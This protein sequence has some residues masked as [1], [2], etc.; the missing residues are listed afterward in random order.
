M[1]N[2]SD[3]VIQIIRLATNFLF[4]WSALYDFDV[5]SEKPGGPPAEVCTGFTRPGYSCQKCL[6]DC[7]H[8]DKSETYCVYGF[9][10]NRHQVEQLLHT[11]FQ[12]EDAITVIRPM[13]EQAVSVSVGIK[14]NYM[15]RIVETLQKILGDKAVYPV[16]SLKETLARLWSEKDRP[17]ILLVLGHYETPQPDKPQITF[18]GNEWLQPSDITRT[19]QKLAKW[20][21]PNPVVVLAACETAAA[22][23]ESITSFLSAFADARASAVIG[24]ETTVFEGLAC[25]FAQEIATSLMQPSAGIEPDKRRTLGDAVL[26]FRRELLLDFN[27]LGLVFTPYG[28]AGLHRL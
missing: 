5:P 28:D 27:P 1:S 4:P 3:G 19:V 22:S 8:P 15:D 2:T 25:R 18:A 13:P 20:K 21:E 11:P 14:G 24:T 7:L 9:W 23:L 12:K 16:Q 17:A 26:Q 6:Q 10:G